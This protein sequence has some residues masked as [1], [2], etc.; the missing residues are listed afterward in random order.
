MAAALL[1]AR[2]TCVFLCLFKSRRCVTRRRRDP[3]LSLEK[4]NA[5]F[6]RSAL[7]SSTAGTPRRLRPLVPRA[8]LASGHRFAHT[9]G[10]AIGSLLAASPL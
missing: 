4:A 1:A 2:P 8:S 5:V 3:P 9:Q 7:G 6:L 10:A